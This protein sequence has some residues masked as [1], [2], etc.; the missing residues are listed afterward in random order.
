[1]QSII[2]KFVLAPAIVLGASLAVNSAMA[3]TVK[4]PF[5]FQAGDKICPAGNYSVTHDDTGNFVVLRGAD[6]SRIFAYVVGP[7]WSDRKDHKI[8]LRF[9]EV[10]NM[11]VLQSIQYDSVATSRL[12]K[13][14][15]DS[16]HD[17]SVMT[18]GR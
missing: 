11:H 3:E 9:D 4:I 16:E 5:T 6:S 13:R 8:A 17:S 1:M 14:V 2:R 18:G 7:T 10:K 15:L 12:D